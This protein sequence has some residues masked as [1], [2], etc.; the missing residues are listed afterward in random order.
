MEWPISLTGNLIL[1]LGPMLKL[2]VHS[3]QIL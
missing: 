2:S 1:R 3:Y